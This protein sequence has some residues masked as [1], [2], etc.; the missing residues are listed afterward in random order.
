MGSS[1]EVVKFKERERTT[2]AKAW[3]DR[4]TLQFTD[5]DPKVHELSIERIEN[6]P[7]LYIAG[8]STSTDQAAEPYNSWGQMITRFF[9]PDIAVA[10]NGESGET[11]RSFKGE[12]RWAKMMSVV[13]PGDYVMIQFGHNDQKE[14]GEGVGA[15][16]TYKADLKAFVADV[17][18]RGAT[19]IVVTPVNRRTFD[20]KGKIINSLG[21]FPPAVRQV[22]EED[23][24]TMV[25]L[26]AMSK[27]LYEAF[28]PEESG[29]L[30]AKGDGTHHSDFG[31]YELAKCVA[32]GLRESRLPLAKLIVPAV[33][34][35]DPAHPDSF[36][37]FDLPP[38]PAATS[39][40]PYGQ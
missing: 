6:L 33:E 14:K 31:S 39:I 40:K 4:L 35:F 8:D 26:N 17:R 10:N 20:G 34:S 1:G 19:A 29:K 3:D 28:G 18:Q 21:D 13:K 5:T 12:K 38:D 37:Q 7:T 24:V 9:K 23:H 32:H 11:L 16:T 36:E 25:D 15:L 30:F 27:P 22:A 2:E